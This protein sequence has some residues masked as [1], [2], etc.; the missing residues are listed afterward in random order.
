MCTA[1]SVHDVKGRKFAVGQKVRVTNTK[2]DPHDEANFG[3]VVEVHPGHVTFNFAEWRTPR[4]TLDQH[5]IVEM[6]GVR[7]V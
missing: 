4:R 1:T 7:I 3:K 5:D 6:Y 2:S